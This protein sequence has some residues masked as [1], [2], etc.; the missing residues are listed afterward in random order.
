MIYKVSCSVFFLASVVLAQQKLMPG[1]LASS[2]A[3]ESDTEGSL[4]PFNAASSSSSDAR[5]PITAQQ[6]IDWVVKGTIGPESLA[7]GLFSAGW[8]TEFNQ[9]KTYGPHWEGFGDRYG[10]RLSG[11][12]VSNTMEAGL[13]AI[14]GEDPRYT[15]DTEA[16]FGHRVGHAAKMTFMA[17]NRDGSVMP[18]YA[19]FLAI[20]GSNFLS[21]TWR[22]TG[23][24]TAGNAA[25]RTGLG[26]LSRFGGNTFDEFW[27]D[28]HRKIFHRGR[29]SDQALLGK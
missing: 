12:A 28:V 20:P 15:R 24:D 17:Q 19:R 22:A 11:I 21:N 29:S 3:P 23:D 10:M 14:W 8:G 6:R 13:G 1:T 7:A 25:V 4:S 5:Q 18:A 26:F 9:P 16:S 27:P 2:A